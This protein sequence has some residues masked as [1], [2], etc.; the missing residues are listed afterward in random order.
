MSSMG[1]DSCTGGGSLV[2]CDPFVH[3]ELWPES[4]SLPDMSGQQPLMVKDLYSS[5]AMR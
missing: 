2:R 1:S 4:T 5:V 3:F